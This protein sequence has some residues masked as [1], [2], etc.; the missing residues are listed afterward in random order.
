MLALRTRV[1]RSMVLPM[2]DCG[3]WQS[4]GVKEVPPS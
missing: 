4:M 3:L 1:G 2:A